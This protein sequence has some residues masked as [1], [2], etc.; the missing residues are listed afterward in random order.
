M[1]DEIDHGRVGDDG[2]GER[3]DFERD[4]DCCGI[5]IDRAGQKCRRAVRVVVI[6]RVFAGT[7]RRSIT[8]II[9]VMAG[10][11]RRDVLAI[12]LA[13]ERQHGTRGQHQRNDECDRAEPHD[14]TSIHAAQSSTCL[15][16]NA[17]PITE[18]ELNVIAALAIIGLS[19]RPN[20]G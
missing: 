5:T 19:N 3:R 12:H 9:R 11:R 16:L 17:F 13:D 14:T 6:A 10:R 15:S 7:N 18:T 8:R 1:H 2:V 20:H 4:G